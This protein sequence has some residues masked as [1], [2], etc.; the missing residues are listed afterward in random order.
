MANLF[1]R[2]LLVFQLNL[3]EKGKRKQPSLTLWEGSI[4]KWRELVSWWS[5][6]KKKKWTWKD[7]ERRSSFFV[8][9]LFCL[10]FNIKPILAPSK[11]T[12]PTMWTKSVSLFLPLTSLTRTQ[13]K[14]KKVEEWGLPSLWD[15]NGL[16]LLVFSILSRTRILISGDGSNILSQ[17]IS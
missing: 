3:T 4:L 17:S 7:K 15:M 11:W 2:L 12:P 6:S 16:G 13:Q 8:F 1:L 9:L 5:I 14:K 10:Y